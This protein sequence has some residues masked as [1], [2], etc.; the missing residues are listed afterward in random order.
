MY[1]TLLARPNIGNKERDQD[2]G[3]PSFPCV[4]LA[5]DNLTSTQK[6]CLFILHSVWVG[7]GFLMAKSLIVFM[8]LLLSQMHPRPQ[9]FPKSMVHQPG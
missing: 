8:T 1:N 6:N 5:F 7:I 4:L 2:G 3:L 9:K